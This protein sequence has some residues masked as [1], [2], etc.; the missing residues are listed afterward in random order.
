MANP[1]IPGLSEAE[2]TKAFDKLNNYNR[3]KK[4]YKDVGCYLVVLPHEGYSK[5]S[6]WIYTPLLERRAVLFISE[7]SEDFY[8][9]MRFVMSELWYSERCIF[10]V[11]YNQ[12][13]MQ[14]HGDDLISFGKYRG[15]YLYEILRIDPSYINW[16]GCK[17]N[18]RI[19]K[20]ERMVKMSQ[21]YMLF[22]MDRLKKKSTQ[23]YR[24]SKFLG[25]KGDKIKSLS[26]KVLRV[27][28]EDDPYLTKVEGN[29]PLFFVRQKIMSVDHNGNL[30]VF[31]IPAQFPSYE[32]GKLSAM[33]KKYVPGEV[34]GIASARIAATYVSHNICFTRLNYVKME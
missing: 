5:Y 34:L 27:N 17:F 26:V 29:T 25:K 12:K 22:Y 19:P 11:D 18:A 31:S 10:L 32:S 30:V 9:S 3:N 14:T 2:M 24:N 13:R 33:E 1:R 23:P 7:L 4:S 15:H 8:I 16:L 6:L 21:A 20:Q 28:P